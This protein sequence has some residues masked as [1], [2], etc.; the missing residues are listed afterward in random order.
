M[1]AASHSGHPLEGHGRFCVSH[2]GPLYCLMQFALEY[3]T[4]C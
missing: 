4:L 1:K 2:F 3:A